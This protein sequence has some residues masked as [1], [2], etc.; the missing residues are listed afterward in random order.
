MQLEQVERFEYS[1]LPWYGLIFLECIIVKEEF[2]NQGYGIK[3]M[4]LLIQYAEENGL[5][6][7]LKPDDKLGTPMHVLEKFYEGLG[8]VWDQ[9]EQSYFYNT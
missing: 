8:F 4:K 9:N 1:E 6:I 3:Q 2:R 5:T 7:E